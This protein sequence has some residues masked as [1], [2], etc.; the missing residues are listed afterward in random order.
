MFGSLGTVFYGLASALVWGTGDFFGG[1]ASKNNSPL[2][3]V[4]VSQFI[5]GCLLFIFALLFRETFVT[6][7]PLLLGAVAGIS[8]ALALLAF[9]TGLSGG[10]MAV[11]APLTAVI[12]SAIP[13]VFASLT[14]GRPANLQI[15]GFI[16]ALFA[17]WLL[18]SGGSSEEA[19]IEDADK[20]KGILSN[21]IFLALA[22]SC[23]S[24]CLGFF[25]LLHSKIS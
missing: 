25:V 14:E 18:S 1:L 8:G 2:K 7:L 15:I 3:V 21:T 11:F 12:T 13:I 23:C 16:L 24:N 19:S 4:L 10:Q 6:G 20:S 17:V 5:G 22:F 9:Y